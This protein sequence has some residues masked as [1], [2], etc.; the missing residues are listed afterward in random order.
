MAC[1]DLRATLVGFQTQFAALEKDLADT[2]APERAAAQKAAQPQLKKLTAEISAARIALNKCLAALAPPPPPPPLPPPP[3]TAMTVSGPQ[4]TITVL[5][6]QSAQ[7]ASRWN[8]AISD[9]MGVIGN[10]FRAPEEIGSA[11]FERASNNKLIP[12]FFD[13]WF[14]QTMPSDNGH[15]YKKSLAGKIQD[16]HIASISGTYEDNDLNIDIVPN[17]NYQDL[18]KYAHPREYTDIMSAEWNLTLHSHGQASCDDA[19][20]VAEFTFIE[21]EVQ[22]SGDIHA[23]AAQLLN[24]MILKRTGSDICVYGPWIYDKGHCCHAEIHPAEQI[25]WSED[26]PNGKKY[27]F[28]VISDAS[29]RFW[30]RDQMDTGTKLIP[31]GAPPIYGLFAIAFDVSFSTI[32][33]AGQQPLVFEVSNM[34]D[35]NV[36]EFPHG[37]QVYSLVYQGQTLIQFL[38]H[39]D[40]F[41]VSFEGVGSSGAQGPGLSTHIRGFLVF[42]TGVG[43]VTQKVTNGLVPKG[44]NVN[45]VTEILERAAFEK[46]EGHY[47]FTVT[48]STSPSSITVSRTTTTTDP[49]KT[50]IDLNGKWAS[51]GSPGPV[52]SVTGNAITVDMSAYKRP[53]A[54][55]SVIDASNITITFPDDKV[56]T[57]KVGVP[58]SIRWSNNSAWTKV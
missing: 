44:S 29:Q 40:A 39:N 12:D 56:Y 47:I 36:K 28:S 34:D 17:P 30:W 27:T 9:Q 42:V 5:G 15:H 23:G 55:G 54:H 46:V 14:P 3:V 26:I 53:T 48:G 1:E 19:A 35:Y 49:I 45:A 24:D 22:V 4:S 32:H 13:F 21:A 52:I 16:V 58:N 25:W 10:D 43:T 50:V 33:A 7:H 20:S 41:E 6:P 11:A 51:G 8:Q 37:N 2:P 57:G 31:W 38:P 18:L